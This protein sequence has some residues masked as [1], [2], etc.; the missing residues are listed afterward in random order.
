MDLSPRNRPSTNPAIA[1]TNPRSEANPA[2]SQAYEQAVA[3]LYGRINYERTAD[4]APYPFRLRRMSELLDRLDLRG[5]A[6]SDIPVVHIAGTKG[7]GSTSSMVASMLTAGGFRTGLYTSPH[8]VRLEERFTV[9]GI[10]AKP[11]AV[12]ELVH[13]IRD[14]ID[15][16]AK[17]DLGPPTFFEVVTAMALMHFRNSRCQAVVLEVGLGGKLDSTNVCVPA[18]TAITSIGFDHQHI[19]GNTLAEIA[20][21]KA[22]IIKSVAPVVSGVI[23]DEPR[24]VIE[25]VARDKQTELIAINRD[26]SVRYHADPPDQADVSTPDASSADSWMA[27]F[28]LISHHPRVESRSQWP[29]PLDGEHQS[30]NAAVA[31]VILDL[32]KSR[33]ATVDSGQQ[34]SGLANVRVAGR[35]ERF[36][37]SPQVDIIL[38]TAHN[39][40]SIEALCRCIQKRAKDRPVIIVFGTS[41]DKE[42]VPMLSQ[43]CEL[44]DHMI[45]TR[46]HGNPRYRDPLELQRDLPVGTQVNVTIIDQPLDAVQAALDQDAGPKLVVICGSFFLAAEVRPM[47]EATFAS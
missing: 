23:P 5:I 27:S 4:T 45:L 12:V 43:L 26:F 42:H 37:V 14:E 32:L 47:L 20:A 31:C 40:D 39:V 18:V 25:Q 19:L 21:Q 17:T 15:R 22:G 9:D 46:Y 24:Q 44:A 35:V 29:L 6:G 2:M 28:D 10:I 7:K 41:R 3:Y 30:R 16:M 33:R 1:I 34:R 38:D 11:E 8:L 13:S 36:R